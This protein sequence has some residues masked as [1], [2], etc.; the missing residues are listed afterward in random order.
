MHTACI[1]A[2]VSIA[3]DCVTIVIA[4]GFCMTCKSM[5]DKLGSP[6]ACTRSVYQAL[7]PLEG[8]GYEARAYSASSR[9]DWD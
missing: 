9:K 3:T 4:C 2:G 6:G 5:D 1:C 7:F 8:P